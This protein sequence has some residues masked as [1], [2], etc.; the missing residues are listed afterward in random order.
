MGFF[1]LQRRVKSAMICGG[2]LRRL[3]AKAHLAN[4]IETME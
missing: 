3:I 2:E 4:E 1:D